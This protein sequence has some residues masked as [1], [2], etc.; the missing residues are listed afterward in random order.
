[1]VLVRNFLSKY[2]GYEEP[3]NTNLAIGKNLLLI[4][5][6][7]QAPVLVN[8]TKCWRKGEGYTDHVQ[9]KRTKDV[10]FYEQMKHYI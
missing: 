10:K 2:E 6:F 7:V 4:V 9:T 1:V 5:V 8:M 3:V